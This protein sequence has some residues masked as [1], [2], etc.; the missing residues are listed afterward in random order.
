MILCDEFTQRQCKGQIDF[1]TL[2]PIRVKGLFLR[3]SYAHSHT[4]THTYAHSHTHTHTHTL[5]R[6]LTHSHTHTHAPIWAYI[7]IDAAI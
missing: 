2:A 5:I 7:E 1:E 4:H 3:H 6:T